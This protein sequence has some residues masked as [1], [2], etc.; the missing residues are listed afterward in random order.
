M[1]EQLANINER[2]SF[3]IIIPLEKV[4]QKLETKESL[5]TSFA[6]FLLFFNQSHSP[7]LSKI[8]NNERVQLPES[9]KYKTKK[10]LNELNFNETVKSDIEKLLTKLYIS[11]IKNDINV[12]KSTEDE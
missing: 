9:L 6:D 1:F 12:G 5:D 4:Y 10:I 7:F 11:N 2:N 3:P 8:T